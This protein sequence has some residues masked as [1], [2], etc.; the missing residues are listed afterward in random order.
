MFNSYKL[1][2]SKFLNKIFNPSS[3]IH[4]FSKSNNIKLEKLD[5]LIK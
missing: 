4:V 5:P 2:K 3:E 1:S